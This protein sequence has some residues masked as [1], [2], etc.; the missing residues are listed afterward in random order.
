MLLPTNNERPNLSLLMT[1]QAVGKCFQGSVR[2]SQLRL[3]RKS[4]NLLLASPND[5]EQCTGGRDV[6]SEMSENVCDER[7]VEGDDTH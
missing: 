6:V 2:D 7:Q 5:W 3:V 1:R 4:A